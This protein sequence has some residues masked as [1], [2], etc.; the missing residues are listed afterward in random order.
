V[1]TLTASTRTS[2]RGANCWFVP[3]TSRNGMT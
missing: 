1:K 2:G 3:W